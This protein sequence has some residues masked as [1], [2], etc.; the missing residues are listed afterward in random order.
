MRDGA[1]ELGTPEERG[2]G[3]GSRR[4][5]GWSG[6][7]GGLTFPASG[8]GRVSWESWELSGVCVGVSSSFQT[9]VEEEPFGELKFHP[10]RL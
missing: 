4:G 6:D 1:E 9:L 8:W 10:Q 2:P 5:V 3:S 7:C